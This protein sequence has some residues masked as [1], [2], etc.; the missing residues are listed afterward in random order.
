MS[1]GVRPEVDAACVAQGLDAAVVGN[2]VAELNDLRDTPEVFDQAGGAAERLARKIVDRDLPVV[3]IGVRDPPQVLEDKILDHAQILPNGRGADL[4]VVADNKSSS[5]EVKASALFLAGP[6]EL[7]QRVRI[8]PQSELILLEPGP[9]LWRR[10]HIRQSAAGVYAR[11]PQPR[12]R[13]TNKG[14]S[15]RR[16]RSFAS[17]L[18][19]TRHTPTM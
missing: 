17:V 13:D 9:R 16:S 19:Q 3:E 5:A 6:M 12:I 11:P 14:S 2:H 8:E 7:V 1:D 15:V 10:D 4:L 18:I